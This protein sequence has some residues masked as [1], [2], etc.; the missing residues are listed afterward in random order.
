[1][2]AY[3]YRVRWTGELSEGGLCVGAADLHRDARSAAELVDHRRVLVDDALVDGQ[4]L[5]DV[6]PVHRQLQQRHYVEPV[7]GNLRHYIAGD[8]CRQRARNSGS[9]S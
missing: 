7:V 3:S 4:K 8:T 5:L 1:M 2:S 6:S 9:I